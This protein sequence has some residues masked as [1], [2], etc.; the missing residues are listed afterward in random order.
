[1][2]VKYIDE[3][4]D[5]RNANTKAYTH[6]FHSYPAMMIPQVAGRLIDKHGKGANLL[7]DPY[8]G[9]GTS[10]VEANLRGINA[11]G[12]DINP[13]ARLI[14]RAKTM[15]LGLKTLEAHIKDFENYVFRIS[16]GAQIKD[17][18]IPSFKNIN[19][20]FD[21]RVQKE[22]AI[23]KDY[24]G[25]IDDRDIANFFN[26]AF[27]ET[28]RECSWT[29]NSEF[30]LFRMTEKEMS[31]F[32]PDVFGIMMSKLARNKKGLEEFMKEK[33]NNAYSL[34]F[35]FNTVE[36]IP[37]DILGEGSVDIVVT[38]PPY[39]DSRTTVAY[40]QFSRLSSQWLGFKDANQIDKLL[41]GG[42]P[43]NESISFS[44][45]VLDKMIERIS[46]KDKER[47]RDIMS[48][49]IDYR[50]SIDNVSKVVKRNGYVCYVVGNRRVKGFT[51]PTDEITVK[52]F[53]AN[54]FKHIETIIRNIPNK[55]MPKKNSPTNEPGKLDTTMSSEHIVIMQKSS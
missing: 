12:T 9:T 5:F 49:Y 25:K 33:K 11:K 52:F 47:A 50:R 14:A 48:F 36:G 10:L 22:L 44:I 53:E 43:K 26:V 40:G 31:N 7:F 4:W 45:D 41:M 28:I 6:C 20:W 16:F 27:S 34:I 38:S 1:M 39:G 2:G 42:Q 18:K 55:R 51:L 17:I 29:K 54:G 46:E 15:F 23:V 32:D 19:Y 35:D 24:I 13:L 37:K 30:K 21:K 3:S 8:C